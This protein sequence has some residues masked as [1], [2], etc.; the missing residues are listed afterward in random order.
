MRKKGITFTILLAT[1]LAFQ[2]QAQENS[3]K[4]LL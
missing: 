2:A 3:V 4:M 1:G